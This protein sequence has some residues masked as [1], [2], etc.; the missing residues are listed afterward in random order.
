[1]PFL[2]VI[3]PIYNAQKYLK[4]CLSSILEQTFRDF[5]L[6]LVNDGSTDQSRAICEECAE[7][8]DNVIVINKKMEAWLVREKQGYKQHREN[9]LHMWMQMIKLI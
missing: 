3:V 5:E 8:N 6:I 7:K 4:T 1:M 9:I 2:S